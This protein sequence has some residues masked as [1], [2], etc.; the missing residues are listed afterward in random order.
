MLQRELNVVNQLRKQFLAILQKTNLPEN[1]WELHIQESFRKFDSDGSGFLEK[2][3][4]RLMIESY[5]VHVTDKG[6]DHLMATMNLSDGKLSYDEFKL[7]VFSKQALKGTSRG[8]SSSNLL[9]RADP[10]VLGDSWEALSS[11][12]N[13]YSM[14][15]EV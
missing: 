9:A 5:G 12:V 1:Q 10:L 3:E 13:G 11:S 8:S 2:E 6:L 7:L 14:N 4:L 15:L